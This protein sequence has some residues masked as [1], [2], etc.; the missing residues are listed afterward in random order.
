[1]F[2]PN[3][4]VACSHPGCP[5][6]RLPP[7][8]GYTHH[9]S[10]VFPPTTSCIIPFSLISSLFIHPSDDSPGDFVHLAVFPP[11]SSAFKHPSFPS[12]I[13]CCQNTCQPEKPRL[14]HLCSCSPRLCC[15]VFSL[16]IR[17]RRST[18]Q[19]V[20]RE[21]RQQ[22]A[23]ALLSTPL[24]RTTSAYHR[25][26]ISEVRLYSCV[27]CFKEHVRGHGLTKFLPCLKLL[28]FQEQARRRGC[29]AV[30]KG[31]VRCYCHVGTFQ[32]EKSPQLRFKRLPL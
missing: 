4:L 28:G 15:Q 17:H 5:T 12:L 19:S 8:L 1:M 10:A 20:S 16:N 18:S 26:S 32:R 14:F 6:T 24:V 13:H 22:R 23:S 27:L 3:H 30:R 11:L 7:S 2:P 25:G 31:C 29:Q 21:R 9:R